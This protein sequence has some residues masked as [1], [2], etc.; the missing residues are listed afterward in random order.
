MMAR[1][2]SELF[3]MGQFVLQDGDTAPPVGSWDQSNG[4]LVTAEVGAVVLTGETYGPVSVAVDVHDARPS[5]ADDPYGFAREETWD[6]IVE[7]GVT[8]EDG[9]LRVCDLNFGFVTGLPDLGPQGH[10][11]YRVRVHVRGRDEPGEDGEGMPVP[12]DKFLIVCWPEPPRPALAIRLTDR[13]GL[14]IR[15]S[16]VA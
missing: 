1:A 3:G 11:T 15:S 13:R 6:D 7:A 5:Q 4:L 9:P 8:C 10:G 16:W 12:S 14:N 2:V